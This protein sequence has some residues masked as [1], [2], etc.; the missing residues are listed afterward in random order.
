MTAT[1]MPVLKL[2]SVSVRFGGLKVLVGLSLEF[3]HDPINCLIGPNGA[4]KTTVFNVLTG[5]VRPNSGR[6]TFGGRDIT[7]ASSLKITRM[8]IVRKFQVPTVF[9]GLAVA[10]NLKLAARAPRDTLAGEPSA[11]TSMESEDV[12][13]ELGLSTKMQVL[14]SELSHGERQWLEIGMA[15]VG[16]PK[17]LLLDEPAAGLGPEESDHTAR[18]I[19][20]ISS[21]C[22]VVV[23]E[24]D[25]RFVRALGGDV[26]VLH[27]GQLLR[28]GTMD[29]VVAD[30]VVRDVYLGRGSNA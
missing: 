11:S 19:K 28:R 18:L 9:P 12:A 29:E 6:L 13:T 27:Q 4:G 2:D 24:H 23:I 20:R 3:G 7:R 1:S 17:L 14:A 10:D 22:R 26:T 5:L 30:P 21:A 25:M 16:R 8:G 15:F